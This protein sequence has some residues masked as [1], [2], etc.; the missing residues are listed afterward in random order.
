[1]LS[2]QLV[3][4]KKAGLLLVAYS[5]VA[6]AVGFFVPAYFLFFLLMSVAILSAIIISQ[7]NFVAVSMVTIASLFFSINFPIPGTEASIRLPSEPLLI[8]SAL[9]FLIRMVRTPVSKIKLDKA[10]KLIILLMFFLACTIPFSSN[11]IISVKAYIIKAIYVL[12]FYFLSKYLLRQYPRLCT[13]WMYILLAASVICIPYFI[14]LHAAYDFNKDAAG[15]VVKPFF[16]D[17]TL[18]SCFLAFL[19]P[20]TLTKIFN[21]TR[22]LLPTLF[23]IFSAIVLIVGI[24]FS[25]CRATW[26]GLL[27]GAA[28]W[29]AMY[30]RIG[31][32]LGVVIL[33]TI[34]VY[35]AFKFD[36]LMVSGIRNRFDSSART[37]DI[38][39]Q[40]KSVA[41]LNN[42]NS[43]LERINRW[44]CALRM[45]AQ[46]PLYG[47]G[48]GNYQF[49]YIPFQLKSEMTPISITSPYNIVE[50]RGG[51]AHNEWLL[52]LSEAGI[53][54]FI[55]LILFIYTVLRFHNV[56]LAN[57]TASYKAAFFGAVIFLVHTLFNNFLDTD[58]VAFLFYTSLV[59][60]T[61]P[62]AQH[63][64][65]ATK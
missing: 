25:S 35:A 10:D 65:N 9:A 43:N 13:Y 24:Y 27:A 47:Y 6:I 26:L 33:L 21:P 22:S 40:L 49:A 58:K 20:F 48:L 37:A 23:F 46:R 45:V 16:N 61:L 5:L 36:E 53:V 50:G 56:K 34:A 32:K 63:E 41:N 14:Y 2:G 7:S 11:V 57:M 55:I 8:V 15:T 1:M 12:N 54:P 31:K 28:L 60:L 62:L 44:S 39:V 42:D 38:E 52:I 19:V 64:R 4:D 59:L 17:H 30:L 18:Y 29:L 51:T 3:I